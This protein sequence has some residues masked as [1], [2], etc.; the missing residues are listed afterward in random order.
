M[1]TL[2]AILLGIVQGLTE[3]LPVSSS[4]HLQIAKELLGVEIEQ[5]ITFDVTLHAATVLSTIVVLWSELWRLIKGCFS[6]RFNEEQAYVLKVI[7][8]MI[9]AGVVGVFFADE[10]EALFSSLWFVGLMLLLTAALLSFAYYAKPRQKSDISYRDA[11]VIGLAQAAATMPGLSRSGS[12]IATGLL[13]G[14]EKS[15]VAHFS[16][17]MVIPVIL[18]KMLLD[19]VS[20]EM[21][22]MSVPTEA[23][24]S[25]FI[26]AFI[27]GALACRFMIEIVKRGRLIWFAAYC[28]IVGCICLITTL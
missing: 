17:I 19:I 23:L 22:T 13:L 24:V 15:A 18:G 11:F 9:P 5:N 4:G 8:S 2:Q 20:G 1:D 16:F 6:R 3:F 28:A 10:I 21:A 25:G 26:A 27:S 14:D 7:L 12:T